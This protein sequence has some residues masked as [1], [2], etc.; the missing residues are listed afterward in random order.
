MVPVYGCDVEL[1][2]DEVTEEVDIFT[3][4][5]F[6]F[7]PSFENVNAQRPFGSQC[8]NQRFSISCY[9]KA[10]EDTAFRNDECSTFSVLVII[11]SVLKSTFCGISQLLG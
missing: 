11:S 8:V 5:S 4:D 10:I 7:I 2:N 9:G 6:D 3:R 1:S